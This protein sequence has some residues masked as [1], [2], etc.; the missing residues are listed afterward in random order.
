MT[1][2]HIACGLIPNDRLDIPKLLN[3]TLE[4]LIFLILGL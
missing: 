3:G 1:A 2:D 4:L